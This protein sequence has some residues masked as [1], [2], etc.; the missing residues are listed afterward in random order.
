[1][2]S[3]YNNTNYTP[4]ANYYM[5][6]I[7]FGTQFNNYLHENYSLNLLRKFTVSANFNLIN[8]HNVTCKVLNARS[9]V[10]CQQRYNE[11]SISRIRLYCWSS[12]SDIRIHEWTVNLLC[13]VSHLNLK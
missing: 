1:M 10:Y 2:I 11:L 5:I 7:N 9:P 6:K 4:N 13:N 12:K 8:K 3:N